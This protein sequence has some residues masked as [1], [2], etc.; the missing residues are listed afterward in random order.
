MEGGG[1]NDR[2]IAAGGDTVIGGAGTD[3]VVI[4]A[5]YDP[6]AITIIPGGFEITLG[7]KVLTVKGVEKFQFLSGTV[8][9]A[10]I[11]ADVVAG[12]GET[13]TLTSGIDLK[14]KKAEGEE[15]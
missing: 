3:T 7:S 4:K 12:T 6:N 8:T 2:F 1:G 11:T 14:A 5:A 15:A 9:S 10:Q 13:F